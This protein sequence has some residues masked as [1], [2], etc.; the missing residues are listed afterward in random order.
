MQSETEFHIHA[1]AGLYALFEAL[2]PA[3]EAGALETL[4]LE[5][6]VLT[7]E[8]AEGKHMVVSKH[9]PSRQLWLASPISGGLHF[10]YG[11]TRWLLADGR[12]LHAVLSADLLTLGVNAT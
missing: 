2:E 6:G 9:A 1:D 7:I 3:Y 10:S 12:E 4:E 5:N 8:T 11:N